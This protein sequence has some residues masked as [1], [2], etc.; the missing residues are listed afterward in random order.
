MTKD[1]NGK[2]QAAVMKGILAVKEK[3]YLTPHYI[4][5]ILSGEDIQKYELA[6]VGDNNKIILPK[7]GKVTLPEL[8]GKGDSSK[9]LIRTYTLRSLDLEKG[10][11][12]VD[13]VAHGDSGPASKWAAE[14]QPGDELGVLMKQKNKKLFPLADWYCITGDHTALPVISVMLESLPADAQGKAV[15]EVHSEADKLDLKKPDNMEV[16]WTYNE[17]PGEHTTLVPYFNELEIPQDGSRFIFAAAE[18]NVVKEI[19]EILRT[20]DNLQRSEW[21]SYS[22]WKYGQAEDDSAKKRSEVAHRGN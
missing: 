9:G 18:Y 20:A 4:R 2:E 3:I 19:Q 17:A 15:I 8:G 16:V 1:N 10:E 21:Q 13:F 5:I 11:M 12:A 22:Y 14:A 6:Q 7:D